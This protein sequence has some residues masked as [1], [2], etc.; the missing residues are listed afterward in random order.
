MGPDYHIWNKM[1]Y[2]SHSY[3]FVWN[4]FH[5]LFKPPCF[6]SYFRE[7]WKRP[8]HSLSPFTEAT[9]SYTS[10]K[11][12][13]KFLLSFVFKLDIFS[14]IITPLLYVFLVFLQTPSYPLTVSV[15]Y[16][17]HKTRSFKPL[18]ENAPWF[19]PHC[20]KT[21]VKPCQLQRSHGPHTLHAKKLWTNQLSNSNYIKCLQITSVHPKVNPS[22]CKPIQL[23]QAGYLDFSLPRK[24]A[25]SSGSTISSPKTIAI[26]GQFTLDYPNIFKLINL[27][28]KNKNLEDGIF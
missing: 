26:I 8:S 13:I 10:I 12:E 24:E 3:L 16:T 21:T 27:W 1:Q 25:V 7:D 11:K 5:K 19:L 9:K 17:K 23:I 4:F 6:T 2:W 20:S 14:V 28:I 22:K 15:Q 18:L